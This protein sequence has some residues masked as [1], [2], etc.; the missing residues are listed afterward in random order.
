MRFL[1][2]ITNVITAHNIITNWNKSEAVIY[3]HKHHL[4]FKL[5]LVSA[6][7]RWLPDKYIIYRDHLINFIINSMAEPPYAV[8]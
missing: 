5:R 1:Q 7:T 3:I 8:F 4:P 2:I 6:T